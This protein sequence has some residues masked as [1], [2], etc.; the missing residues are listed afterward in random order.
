MIDVN[1]WLSRW[2]FRRLPEDEPAAL[3]RRLRALGV[4]EAWAGSFDALLHEDIEA[5]NAR[6][7]RDCRA[8]GDGL[9]RPFGAVNPRLPD[10]P[11]DLRR[12][13]EVHGMPGVRLHPDFHGYPLDDPAFATL[14]AEADRL[15]LIVQLALKMEDERTLHPLLKGL[16]MP[17]VTPLAGLLGRHPRLRLVLLNGLRDLR[18]PTL[19]RLLAAGQVYLDIAMLEGVGGLERLVRTI[20]P[21]RLLFGS[22]AP[23]FYAE[24]AHQKL[25]ESSLTAEQSEAI[26]RGNALRLLGPS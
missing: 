6:L 25:R 5:V 21:G 17:D 16:A 26:R 7:A 2:P 11:E 15:G 10:W 19:A 3:V 12:C 4:S 1:V 8:H 14:L 23:F 24:S 9:L 18:G 22:Y 13:R 20:D